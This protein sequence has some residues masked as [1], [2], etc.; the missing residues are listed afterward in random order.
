MIFT[1]K[2]KLKS[3]SEIQLEG[4]KFLEGLGVV[5][6]RTNSGKVRV[7]GG[8]MQLCKNGWPDVTGYSDKAI[9][10]GIEFKDV[11]SW[12][13]K[14]NG[15]SSDQIESLIDIASKGGL[16]GVACC[17]EHIERILKGEKVGSIFT[18]RIVQTI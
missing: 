9:F 1:D 17:N 13:S 18:N 10:I 16:C 5:A 11:K 3:E 7:R 8:W 14:N 4:V 12:L 2:Q 6:T 15:A